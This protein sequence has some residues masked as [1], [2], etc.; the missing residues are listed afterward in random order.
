[1]SG[2]SAVVSA[3]RTEGQRRTERMR[4]RC[5][6]AGLAGGGFLVVAV[7]RIAEGASWGLTALMVVVA[8]LMLVP[9]VAYLRATGGRPVRREVA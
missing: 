8:V 2:R 6:R 3:G 9:A 5:W 1:M 7:V 4:R